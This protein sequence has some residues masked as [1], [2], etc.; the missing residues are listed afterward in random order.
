MWNAPQILNSSQCEAHATVWTCAPCTPQFGLPRRL[1]VGRKT[2]QCH[3]CAAS[4]GRGAFVASIEQY[5]PKQPC[6]REYTKLNGRPDSPL[7]SMVVRAL[8]CAYSSV[9]VVTTISLLNPMCLAQVH[10]LVCVTPSHPPLSSFMPPHPAFPLAKFP[11]PNQVPPSSMA[12]SPCNH[13]PC[14]TAKCYPNSQVCPTPAARSLLPEHPSPPFKYPSPL[15]CKQVPP[16]RG[17]VRPPPLLRKYFKHFRERVLAT[18]DQGD[19]LVF[20]S[21]CQEPRSE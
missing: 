21:A 3:L 5:T 10:K 17:Q 18:S 16:S 4:H 8:I 7:N 13:S 20:V 19:D 11:L 9:L 14:P 1:S 2:L 15:P 12:K 6:H